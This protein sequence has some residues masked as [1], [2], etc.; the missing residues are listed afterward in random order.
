MFSHCD[1]ILLYLLSSK[2]HRRVTRK[3]HIGHTLIELCRFGALVL[4]AARVRLL[5]DQ[6]WL[7]LWAVATLLA[8]CQAYWLQVTAR[9]VATTARLINHTLG[10]YACNAQNVFASAWQQNTWQMVKMI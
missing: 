5:V 4:G 6:D 2:H 9:S 8:H 3:T 7:R 10:A 1:R